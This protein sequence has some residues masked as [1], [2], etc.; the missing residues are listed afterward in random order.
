MLESLKSGDWQLFMQDKK[1]NKKAEFILDEG[2]CKVTFVGVVDDSELLRQI[3]D[4]LDEL[5]GK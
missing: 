2:K 1:G 3:A 4:K 5:N